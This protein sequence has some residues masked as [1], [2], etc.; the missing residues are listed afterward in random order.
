LTITDAVLR[1]KIL[2]IADEVIKAIL[3]KQLGVDIGELIPQ[4]DG[5]TERFA[6][7]LKGLSV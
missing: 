2:G 5:E 4:T 7:L 3:E 1:M 6:N